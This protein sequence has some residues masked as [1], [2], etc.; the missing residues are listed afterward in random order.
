MD[1]TECGE[2]R[3]GSVVGRS[4]VTRLSVKCASLVSRTVCLIRWA[5]HLRREMADAPRPALRDRAGERGRDESCVASLSRLAG[6]RV[7]VRWDPREVWLVPAELP[8]GQRL[9]TRPPS[10][11]DRD[12]SEWVGMG[13]S[14]SPPVLTWR[15]LLLPPPATPPRRPVLPPLRANRTCSTLP[16]Q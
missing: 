15:K 7:G 16:P 12:G 13:T 6:P 11:E 3:R 4:R 5:T 10:S 9:M 1:D 8:A 2:H 14:P